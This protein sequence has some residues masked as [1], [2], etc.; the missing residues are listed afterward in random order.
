MIWDEVKAA[1]WD[2]GVCKRILGI[3]T[4]NEALKL[5]L[6]YLKEAWALMRPSFVEFATR[7]MI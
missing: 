6:E 1:I 3:N 4:R 2:D 7:L 5:V